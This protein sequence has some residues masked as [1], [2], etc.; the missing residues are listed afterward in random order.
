M[1][2]EVSGGTFPQ[3]RIRIFTIYCESGQLI[4]C[5]V[6]PKDL[7]DPKGWCVYPAGSEGSLHPYRFSKS[8]RSIV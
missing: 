3:C 2:P 4:K 5:F 6:H 8:S 1:Y 7:S